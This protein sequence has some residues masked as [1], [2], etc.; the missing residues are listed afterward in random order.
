L[1]ELQQAE[2][3]TAA[4]EETLDS[5]KNLTPTEL[6]SALDDA[7]EQVAQALDAIPEPSPELQGILNRLESLVTRIISLEAANETIQSPAIIEVIPE[8][9]DP[10]TQRTIKQRLAGRWW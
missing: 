1:D 2:I 6:D 7:R 8:S 5:T 9:P 4:A 10:V 3:Q